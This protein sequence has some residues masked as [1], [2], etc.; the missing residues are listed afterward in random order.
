MIPAINEA[1]LTLS[2]SLAASIVAKVTVITA[3]ALFAAWLARG[4]RAAVRHA[5]LA[6][7]FGVTLLLPI[8]S[9]LVPPVHV[10]VPVAAEVRASVEPPPARSVEQVPPVVI[11]DEPDVPVISVP[12]SPHLS[13]SNL[14]L[15][16]WIAGVAIF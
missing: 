14:L 8:A 13:L 7:A 1:I 3:L 11:T 15:T 4:S 9:V 2:S 10:A 5:F 6:A 16:G 12:Q